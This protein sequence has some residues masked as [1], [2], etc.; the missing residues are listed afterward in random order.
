MGFIAAIGYIPSSIARLVKLT[1]LNIQGNANLIGK[2]VGS[3]ESLSYY[4]Y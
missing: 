2:A 4:F 1:G 3:I